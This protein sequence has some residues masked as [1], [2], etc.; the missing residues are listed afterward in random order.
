MYCWQFGFLFLLV[1]GESFQWKL[2]G[3]NL[4]KSNVC[5]SSD[6]SNLQKRLGS[7]VCQTENGAAGGL[8]GQ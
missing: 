6:R 7:G 4:G 3:I 2:G 1:V 8:Q 5:A